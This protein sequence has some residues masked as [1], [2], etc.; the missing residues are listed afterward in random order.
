L[1]VDETGKAIAKNPKTK[2]NAHSTMGRA[3]DINPSGDFIAI[4]MRDGH[5]RVYSTK[6]WKLTYRKRISKEWIE[7]LKFSPNG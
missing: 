3:V 5:L 6:T 4:G 7:D 1:T 2:E